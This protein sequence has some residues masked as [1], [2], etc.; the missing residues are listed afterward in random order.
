MNVTQWIR[1]CKEFFIK[2]QKNFGLHRVITVFD[3]SSF[4]VHKDRLVT[5]HSRLVGSYKGD[6]HGL[7]FPI[8]RGDRL[9]KD[10]IVYVDSSSSHLLTEQTKNEFLTPL[11]PGPEEKTLGRVVLVHN[12]PET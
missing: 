2:F 5:T 7:T 9:V 10:V 4:G 1:F 3:P 12:R 11:E 8:D 6:S